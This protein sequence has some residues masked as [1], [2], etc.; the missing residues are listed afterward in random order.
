MVGIF[1][2]GPWLGD[3]EGILVGTFG[4]APDWDNQTDF[5]LE[6]MKVR[7]SGERVEMWLG[8]QKEDVTRSNGQIWSWWMHGSGAGWVQWTT[9]Y[10]EV[11]KPRLFDHTHRDARTKG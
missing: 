1:L 2:T 10:S 7:R 5:W 11:T 9:N 4:T 8:G 3:S 6:S